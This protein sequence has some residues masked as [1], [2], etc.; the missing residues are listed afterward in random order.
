MRRLK[1]SVSSWYTPSSLRACRRRLPSSGD[2]RLRVT[3]DHDSRHGLTERILVGP[4]MRR[5]GFDRIR[6]RYEDE[7]GF[8][9]SNLL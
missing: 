2:G 9:I 1:R 5:L 8:Q 3:V 7:L 4:D 6:L